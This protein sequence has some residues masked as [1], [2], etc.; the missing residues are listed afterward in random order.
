MKKTNLV[1]FGDILSHATTLGYDWN[2]I[3][4]V[5]VKDGI[6]PMYEQN[7]VDVYLSDVRSNAY[8]WTNDTVKIL[9]SFLEKNKVTL[10]TIS[11]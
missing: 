11:Q 9:Q 3:H 5:L 8:G 2:S 7:S 1:D 10:V 6:C 4:D